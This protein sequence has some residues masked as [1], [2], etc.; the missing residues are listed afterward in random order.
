MTEFPD[1]RR[2]SVYELL[3]KCNWNA[4][5]SSHVT[6]IALKLFDETRPYHKLTDNDRELLEY[7]ALMH[8]IGYHISHHKHHRHAL[9]L[10]QNADLKGFTQDEI[11][12]MGHVAR[13]HRRS[14]P[15][16][17]HSEFYTLESAVKEKIVKLSGFMRVADGLD[18]SHYQNVRDLKVVMKG[19]KAVIY[20]RTHSDAELEIWGAMRKCE[21]FEKLFDR[22]LEIRVS[23]SLKSVPA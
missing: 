13:Y 1:P 4:R 17:R 14:T 22:K 23:K 18:R 19:K 12:I 10:I 8:D 11:Q 9:Y 21:L 7:A 3:Q 2:R 5:H 16:K 6:K 15:K 20:I